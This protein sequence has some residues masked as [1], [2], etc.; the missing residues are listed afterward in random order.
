MSR[1]NELCQ[2][3]VAHSLRPRLYQQADRFP[4]H[5]YLRIVYNDALTYDPATKKGGL[6]ANFVFPK[7]ARSA[8]NKNL[9]LL[10]S[11]LI[12][13]KQ[14]EEINVMDKL[15]LSDYFVSAATLVV[16]EAEGPNV[17]KDLTFGRKDV[18]SEA[19]AG[20]VSQIPA[21]GAGYK[22]ALKAKGFDD[23]EIVSLA[24]IEAFGC[25]WDPKKRDVSREPKLDNFYYKQLL[26]PSANV[27]LKSE[28]TGDAELKAIVEKFAQDPKAFHESFAKAFLKLTSLG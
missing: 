20:D 5:L 9:Q 6:K 16:K 12:Y 11:E 17:L 21:A 10:I 15:S 13:Q 4:W 1:I 25:V 18:A 26:S 14:H 28:L 24:A 3:F 8:Q 2:Q 19:E 22:S 27:V 7:V 23:A